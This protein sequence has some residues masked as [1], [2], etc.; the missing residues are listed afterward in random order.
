MEAHA[1]NKDLEN[2]PPTLESLQAKVLEL[3]VKLHDATKH[4]SFAWIYS[5]VDIIYVATVYAIEQLFSECGENPRVFLMAAAYFGIMFSTRNHFDVYAHTFKV[6]KENEIIRIIVFILYCLGVYNMTL[7]IAF[8]ANEEDTTESGNSIYYGTCARSITYDEGFGA[9]FIVSRCAIMA[10]Y[11][12]HFF[13]AD[14][15]EKPTR[16]FQLLMLKKF[17]PIILTIVIMFIIFTGHSPVIIFP[18]IALV[19]FF[20]DRISD[21]FIKLP[22]CLLPEP[23]AYQERLGAMFMLVLGETMVGLLF[24]HY[25][26]HRP[27]RTYA[28]VM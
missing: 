12:Y 5:F 21:I 14:L 9:S 10:L 1:E 23:A 18:V 20:G 26:P 27:L 16:E 8:T 7:N 4:Q 3:Q 6:K 11:L 28:T 2:G 25:N 13:H 22:A 17:I 19:E 15:G 24:V